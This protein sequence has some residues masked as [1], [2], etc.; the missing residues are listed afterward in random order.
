MSE[1]LLPWNARPR[2]EAA[3][4]N[5]AFLAVLLSAA[6]GDHERIADSGMPWTLA[7]LVPPL[8]LFEDTRAELPERTNARVASWIT[9]NS[10]VRGRLPLRARSLGPLVREGTRFGVRAGA[11]RF[12]AERLT[13]RLDAVSL[14]ASTSGEAKQCVEKAAF[15]GRWLTKVSDIASVYALLGISP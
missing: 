15:L 1:V 6:A 8:V 14:R 5:P 4:F 13:S 2:E 10:G 7:F 3:L 12:E 9:T 11:L